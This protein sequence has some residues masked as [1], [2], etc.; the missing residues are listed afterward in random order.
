MVCVLRLCSGLRKEASRKSF[1]EEVSCVQP[2]GR[3]GAQESK[4]TVGANAE[5]GSI[6]ALHAI[7]CRLHT[8]IHHEPRAARNSAPTLSSAPD[9]ESEEADHIH[10]E[11]RSPPTSGQ[12]TYPRWLSLTEHLP[13][14]LSAFSR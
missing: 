13:S 8:G 2:D 11:L 14:Y 4:L 9:E 10:T 7:Y 1:R 6:W 3:G 5:W 12:P